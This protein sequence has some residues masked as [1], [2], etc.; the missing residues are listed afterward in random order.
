MAVVSAAAGAGLVLVG[1][2]AA[3][4]SGSAGAGSDAGVGLFLVGEEA[5]EGSGAAVAAAGL[6]LGCVGVR[7][8]P[9]EAVLG[10]FI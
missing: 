2:E 1:E 10:L 4:D 5:A 3:E 9:P 7:T 6:E 8:E